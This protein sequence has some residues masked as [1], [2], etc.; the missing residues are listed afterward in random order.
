MTAQLLDGEAVASR[1]R[2]TLYGRVKALCKRGVHPGLGT[3]LVGE[4]SSSARYVEMKHHDCLEVGIVPFHRHIATS[5]TTSHVIEVVR[6]FNAN[7]AIHA[8]LVQL[9][10]PDAVDEDA[11]L[12][13][14]DPAK[15]ADGLHPVNLGYLAMG[16][17]RVVPCT[18]A[19]IVALLDAYGISLEGR[20]LVVVGRGLTIGRP[21]AMLATL[22]RPGYNAAVTV[23]HSR[24]LDLASLVRQ[25]DVVVAAA[26]SPGL[27]TAD[28]VK[29]G[30]VVVGAGTSFAGRRLLS[31]IADDVAELASW[32]TPRIGGVGPMTRA[33]L[34]VNAVEAAERVV[35]SV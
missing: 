23:G 2:E 25:G 5:A 31:D 15:D 32:V 20:H 14:L 6:E 33:M 19:G 3:I 30:A 27:I 22:N 18:P 28:M 35:G 29:P 16:R 4:D 1:I 13:A 12:A 34:L 21:L 24:V 8:F 10:L 26:G 11:V 7:P 9:P 17:P